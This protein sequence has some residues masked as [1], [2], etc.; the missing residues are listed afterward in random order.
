[1]ISMKTKTIKQ[2]V[3]FKASPHEVYEALM[4]S[5]KHSTFTGDKAD[6]GKKV[7]DKF[8]AYGDYIEGEN[9][10]LIPSKK[11]VQK[12]RA[13]DW[14]E[15]YYS[16]VTFLLKNIKEGTQL[17]FIHEGVPEEHYEDIKQ[18]WIDHYWDKMKESFGW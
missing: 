15:G 17:N 12:W 4:D 16:K 13:I 7:G 18:G 10:E 8:T 3:I 6:I 2:T 9:M 1:M 11:I 5:K 14:P